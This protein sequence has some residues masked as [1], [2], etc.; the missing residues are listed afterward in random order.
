VDYAIKIEK[1]MEIENAINAMIYLA[2]KKGNYRKGDKL[3]IVVSNP[4][5]HYDIST[6]VQSDVKAIEFM[7]HIAKILSSNESLNITQC[8]FNVKIFSIPVAVNLTKS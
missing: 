6:D 1:I 7:K 3:I 5:F 8:H 4:N 2:K